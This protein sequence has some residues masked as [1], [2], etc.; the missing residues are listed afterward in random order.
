MLLL[1]C[2]VQLALLVLSLTS[3]LVR[4]ALISDAGLPKAAYLTVHTLAIEAVY[5]T[6]ATCEC[7]L[8]EAF[9]APAWLT[10]LAH[11]ADAFVMALGCLLCA[12]YYVLVH[13]EA[14]YRRRGSAWL[15]LNNVVHLP[16]AIVPLAAAAAKPPAFLSAHAASLRL[17]AVAATAYAA[18]YA[19]YVDSQP[20]AP[21]AFLARLAPPR[22]A[23]WTAGIVLAVLPFLA[24]A[25][26]VVRAL[27]VSET[28]RTRDWVRSLAVLIC[29]DIFS[30]G[31]VIAT[32]VR[33]R[34]SKPLRFR[35]L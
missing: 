14:S 21:Y 34:P 9:V 13:F 8:R 10:A 20:S 28:Y 11:A 35:Q 24:A 31:T 4:H 5:G 33:R 26:A 2:L 29:L 3:N 7:G 32:I 18:T 25:H 27:A 23:F 1:P 6:I 30:L 22:I 15:I 16:T 17:Q 12:S 19:A